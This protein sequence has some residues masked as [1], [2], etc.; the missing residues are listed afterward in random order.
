M[1]RLSLLAAWI[2][3]FF[4]S[5]V[6]P[7]GAA[8]QI[9]LPTPIPITDTEPYRGGQLEQWEA[10]GAFHS[11][12]LRGS[13][14][15]YPVPAV[16]SAWQIHADGR[17]LDLTLATDAK[18]SD[19]TPIT[20]QDVKAS[21][22]RTLRLE[23]NSANRLWL[24]LKN[25]SSDSLQ[26]KGSGRITVLMN[27]GCTKQMLEQLSSERFPILHR[28]SYDASGS[29]R[30]SG[31]FSGVFIYNK[32]DDGVVVFSPN[33]SHALWRERA[34]VEFH[35][36]HLGRKIAPADLAQ[37]D[38]LRTFDSKLV[39]EARKA[40][41]LAKYS[42]PV[43]TWFVT[44]SAE[45]F[46]REPQASFRLMRFL[47]GNLDPGRLPY[48]ANGDLETP[49][50]VFFPAE[51]RCSSQSQGAQAAVAVAAAG[52]PPVI[53]EESVPGESVG[54]S[55]E[56]RQEM[57][58][59]G[60]KV[61]PADSKDRGAIRLKLWRQFL[62]N[63]IAEVSDTLWVVL[64]KIPDPERL[65]EKAINQS[66]EPMTDPKLKEILCAAP[67][68]ALV[69]PIAH[70]RVAYL[71]RVKWMEGLF[72]KFSANITYFRAPALR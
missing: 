44:A 51:F 39:A 49:T 5:L 47:K 50:Q 46:Q 2:V 61:L 9:R 7:A 69:L 42:L 3:V 26:I 32:R 4:S 14:T 8:Q 55:D 13:G 70:R 62:G 57:T 40:G 28:D 38:V 10:L 29:Y 30:S 27:P 21:L 64:K 20:A 19:G 45:S 35:I 66:Q 25:H 6:M 31:K 59:A 23:S 12:V 37:F 34:P 22:A 60:L 71:Y 1:I 11:S 16:A 43:M 54:F 63:N 36:R 15:G 52:L 65:V 68:G 17:G 41:F 48:F 72:E 56:L 33:P 24:C 58:R 67:N 18:F 53:L